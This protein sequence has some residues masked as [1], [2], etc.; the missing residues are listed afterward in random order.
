MPQNESSDLKE[1]VRN[2]RSDFTKNAL[3]KA[4]ALPDPFEQFGLWIGEAV[5]KKLSDPNAM[6]LSTATPEGRPSSRVVLLRGFEDSAFTF[7]TNY[8][9]RKGEEIAANP[10]AALLFFWA[11]IEKQVRIEGRI[12]KAA[13]EV[14]DAYFASR[15]RESRIGA[16]A[17]PQ[18]R[19]IE[20]RAE[21]EQKY[22]DLS[23]RFAEREIECP[24]NWGGYIL[25][26]ERFEFWQ[27]RASRLHDRLLYTKNG[28]EWAIERLAP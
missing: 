11:E 5:E 25:K 12:E 15:P 3:E 7:F 9:S 10:Q 18:S 24:P 23:E 2:L 21:L 28:A 26:P 8:D 16:W 22:A 13:P 20:N 19:A 4:S 27:G 14:S 17:S 6:I 1:M